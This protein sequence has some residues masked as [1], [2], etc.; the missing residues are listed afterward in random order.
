MQGYD[1]IGDV[2]GRAQQLEA[3]LQLLGYQCQ[4]GVY[5]HPS[6]QAIFIGDMIDYGPEQRA[7]LSIPR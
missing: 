7:T 2:H 4:A 5:H 6:R 1:V 3:L